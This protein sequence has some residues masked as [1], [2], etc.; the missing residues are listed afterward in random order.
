MRM[1]LTF[2]L[3]VAALLS[4]QTPVPDARA[5][6]GIAHVAFRVSD[7]ARSREFYQNLG[8]E[9]AFE[10]T[11]AKGAT[12]SY[13]KVND[14]QFIEL[15]RR[16]DESQ[17]L[18]LMH[19]CFDAGDL[20]K[21]RAAYVERGLKPAEIVKARA[22]NLLFSMR[23]LEGLLLEYTQYM[24][25]SL[26]FNERGKHLGPRR[27]SERL[28]AA[29]TAVKDLAAEREF[30]TATLGFV[31]EKQ[32]LRVPG[33]SVESVTLEALTPDWKPRLE[34]LVE[35]V[36]R[37]ADELK[38]QG[39]MVTKSGRTAMVHDPDGTVLLFGFLR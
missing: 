12:V 35:D 3:A 1:S 13:I 5:L 21:V 34:F 8:F 32:G 17:P 37:A 15:Y 14:R 19:V 20:A 9:Q 30:Y 4:G 23:D 33:D 39:L 25:G 2:L 6:D 38:H 16:D 29:S 24:P 26:H 10:F 11:D 27:I 36:E 7:L 22:G 18:G 28:R 31:D